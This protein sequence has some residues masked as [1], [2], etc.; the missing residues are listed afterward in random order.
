[1]RLE[2]VV[3]DRLC[4]VR[5]LDDDVGLREAAL[6]VAAV[7]RARL[8]K[9]LPSAHRLLRIEQRLEHLVL[10]VDHRER[11]AGL[12]ERVGGHGGDGLA[13]EVGLAHKLRNRLGLEHGVHARRL[14]RARR[15]ERLHAR[16]CVRR[17]Q[18]GGLEHPRQLQVGR[19]ERLA[20]RA[21]EAVLPRG[22]TADDVAWAVSPGVERVLFDDEPDFFEAAFDFLLG[23]DQSCHVRIASSIFG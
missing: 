2:R 9:Q 23:A 5:P 17:A 22:G 13:L 10:D 11:R 4:A 7:E 3:Q 21:L 6:G 14:E 19:V 12:R 18:H 16:A 15:V 8:G 1:M 20:R